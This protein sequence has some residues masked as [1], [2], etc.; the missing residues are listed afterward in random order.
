VRNA[1]VPELARLSAAS[2][3]ELFRS[4]KLSP[5]DALKQI[6][7][8]VL[9]Q[10]QFVNA[11][12]VY[13]PDEAF[14][15]AKAS[16]DR[17]FRGAALGPLDGIAVTLKDLLLVA[18]WP[19]LKGS[20]AI[21][22]EGEWNED[23]PAAK[24]LKAAGAL[25][26]GKT[27]TSEFG[28]IALTENLAT[29]VTRSP[30]DLSR[31]PGGSSGG[32]AVA[33]ALGFG[34]VHIS[35]DG[36]GSTRLP[37]AVSGIFGIKPTFGRAPGYPSAHSGSMFHIGC[38]ARN[39]TDAVSLLDAVSGRDARDWM[40]M[41]AVTPI[42]DLIASDIRGLRIAFSPNLGF[43]SVDPEVAKL[44]EA[45][46]ERFRSLGAI[47]ELIDP[48][49]GDPADF[50]RTLMD[51]AIAKLL[52]DIPVERHALIE[53]GFVASGERGKQ[54]AAVEYV[55]AMEAREA[56]GRHMALFHEQWDI[57]LTP[58]TPFAA[59][60]TSEHSADGKPEL[61][62][63]QFTYPFNLTQQP[64]VSVPIGFTSQGMPV[65]MQLIGAKYNDALVLRAAFNF[66]RA[67]PFIPLWEAPPCH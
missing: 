32:A 1:P 21:E 56:L 24:Q 28:W 14:K 10:N 47:V 22:P 58:T 27:T 54:I 62:G 35:T 8:H 5:V 16:E 29:G 49:F 37:S 53:P 50:R 40:A 66:E 46:A 48:G 52:S 11:F 41:P 20:R 2:L 15:R 51:A 63:T 7:Q 64:S 39:V 67:A 13:D 61:L 33:T 44:V 25:I 34:P 18:G 57:L 42:K 23:S 17:W 4:K 43:V 36:G 19:T 38:M 26:T 59:G 3:V 65:G 60:L 30:W 31:T 9:D 12:V 6:H 45:A 55:R